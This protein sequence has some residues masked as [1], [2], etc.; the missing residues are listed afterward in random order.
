MRHQDY[1][2][3]LQ[4]RLSEFQAHSKQ[5]ENLALVCHFQKL[6]NLRF[7]HHHHRQNLDHPILYHVWC[8][9]Q[10]VLHNIVYGRR[11]R[12][13][14]CNGY[15]RRKLTLCHILTERR[16]GKYV[17]SSKLIKSLL[18]T[19]WWRNLIIFVEYFFHFSLWFNDKAGLLKTILNCWRFDHEKC[20]FHHVHGLQN[21]SL[22]GHFGQRDWGCSIDRCD[23]HSNK[24]P[25]IIRFEWTNDALIQSLNETGGVW[26]HERQFDVWQIC[27]RQ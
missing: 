24:F 17:R 7:Q 2:F 27:T 14:W 22:H 3:L 8:P 13:P 25:T 4:S 5:P 11:R 19:R 26:W 18:H 12:C 16:V 21:S 9:C 20:S 15:R 6:Q 1:C 23:L 10:S